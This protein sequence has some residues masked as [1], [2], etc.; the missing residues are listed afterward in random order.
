M[1]VEGCALQ[2]LC[3]TSTGVEDM[4]ELL[5]PFSGAWGN[6]RRRRTVSSK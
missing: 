2:L 1:N 3:A 4:I 5:R 6:A